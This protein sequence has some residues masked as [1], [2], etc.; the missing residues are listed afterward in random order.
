MH[1]RA[2]TGILATVGIILVGSLFL[3][4]ADNKDAGQES[5]AQSAPLTQTGEPTCIQVG[6]E[7]EYAVSYSFFSIGTVRFKILGQGVREGRPIFKAQARIESNPGLSWLTDVHIRFYAEIDDSVFSHYWLSED[8]SKSGIDY[9]SLTFYYP[10]RNVIYQKG[11]VSPSG[12]NKI[13]EQDTV[14]VTGPEEDGLSLFY[15]AREHVR[16]KKL[17]TVS[18][19]IDNKEKKT[20]IDFQNKIEDV[21]IDAVKYPVETVYFNG[22]ADFVGVVGLTGG[23]R[24]WFSNDAARVPIMARLNVWIGSIKVELKSWNRPGWQPPEYKSDH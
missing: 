18:T 19:F 23:F 12:V 17:D 10:D 8:S 9:H 5:K 1:L 13:E 14:A 16:Q 21:D 4:W 2:T 22:H 15:Y 20:Y 11:N 3:G 6:E 24:G 7:L